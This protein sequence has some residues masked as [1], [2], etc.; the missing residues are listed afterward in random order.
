[1]FCLWQLQ[2]FVLSLH[3]TELA[4]ILKKFYDKNKEKR[5]QKLLFL[6][7]IGTNCTKKNPLIMSKGK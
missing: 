6:I 3:N 2:M 7:L 5:D 4:E 1:M